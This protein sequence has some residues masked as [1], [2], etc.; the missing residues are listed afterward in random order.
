M[1]QHLLR[2]LRRQGVSQQELLQGPSQGLVPTWQSPQLGWLHMTRLQAP[3]A[4]WDVKRMMNRKQKRREQTDATALSRAHATNM[5]KACLGNSSRG[6]NGSQTTE[7]KRLNLHNSSH[8]IKHSPS[9]ASSERLAAFGPRLEAMWA[10][11]C[12][13]FLLKDGSGSN[14]Q[15]GRK[16]PVWAIYVFTQVCME[17]DNRMR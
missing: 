17:I 8:S 9:K 11:H 14:A 4:K 12:G 16:A 2:V 6:I 3:R 1:Q 10:Q 5:K 15:R 7:K 13:A